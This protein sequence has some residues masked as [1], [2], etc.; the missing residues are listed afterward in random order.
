MDKTMG[1]KIREL[2]ETRGYS[3]RDMAFRLGLSQA[4]YS[5]WEA[6]KITRYIPE[7]VKK[8]AQVLGT[9]QE[10]LMGTEDRLEHHPEPIQKWLESP[11]SIPY[12]IQAYAQY[13]LEKSQKI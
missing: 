4:S 5:R 3:Q 7:H 1:E 11:E 8:I 13:L 2:R 9:T 12:V 6:D 10:Y